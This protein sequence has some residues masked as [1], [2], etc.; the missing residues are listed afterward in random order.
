MKNIPG[1]WQDAPSEVVAVE[2]L[3]QEFVRSF[4]G[5]VVHD[6]IPEP[7]RFQNA[8]FAFID[9]GV[10]AELK[11]IETEFSHTEAFRSGFR[12]CY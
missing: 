10:I 2:P 9:Q 11:E 1:F 4:G 6:V 3:W 7:R 5:L 8:D 12:A